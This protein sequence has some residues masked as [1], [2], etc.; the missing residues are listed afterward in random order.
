M[1]CIPR[2][3]VVV[4]MKL[5][6]TC[7]SLRTCSWRIISEDMDIFTQTNLAFLTIVRPMCR[8]SSFQHTDFALSCVWR[9]SFEHSCRIYC[10]MAVLTLFCRRLRSCTWRK[11]WICRS[12]WSVHSWCIVQEVLVVN[13]IL[14]FTCG[15]SVRKKMSPGTLKHTYLREVHALTLSWIAYDCSCL[16]LPLQVGVIYTHCIEQYRWMPLPILNTI[17]WK[18]VHRILRSDF[19]VDP[20]CQLLACICCTLLRIEVQ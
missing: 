19:W 5:I 17:F 2:L 16:L 9:G 4:L 8:I 14:P 18:S 10:C 12:R 1:I 20:F 13:G 11:V 7:H 15:N 3:V 6:P